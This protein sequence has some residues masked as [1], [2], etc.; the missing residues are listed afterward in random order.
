MQFIDLSK[1]QEGIR[2]NIEARI[3]NVLD[4]GKYI[5]GPEIFELEERLANYVNVKHC[6][7][8][9]SGTDALLISLMAKG[10]GSGDAVITTPFSFI[11]TAEVI[12]LIGATPVFVDICSD[13]FNINPGLIPAAIQY[14]HEHDLNPKAIIPVDLF[15]LPAEYNLIKKIAAENELFILEDAAQGFGGEFCGKKACSFGDFAA[16]SFFPA[17]PLGCYGDGGAI[18]TNDDKM[19][20]NIRS[21]RVHGGGTNKY[22]NILLGINGRLDT[23][24]AAILLGKLDIFPGEVVKRNQ[25]AAYYTN[26]LPDQYRAPFIPENYLS[27]WAQYSILL[28]SHQDRDK[29]IKLLS[30]QNIP[31]MIYYRIPLHLQKVFDYL[32]YQEGD[33]PIAEKTSENILSIPMHPYLE[34]SDQ[35]KILEVLH[36][37]VE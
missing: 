19:V 22:D 26:N 28:K 16:T 9:S 25:L 24:Q 27:S 29:T 18:F 15:G 31:A 35:D 1:Q 23:L 34:T 8:C 36:A 30:K 11:A 17:K 14:A 3:K 21:I 10:I 12:S 33:F 2:E 13:T 20:H 5:M 32:G 7:T 37:A 6:I 4:S